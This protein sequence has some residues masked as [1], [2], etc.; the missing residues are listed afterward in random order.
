MPVAVMEQVAAAPQ[1]AKQLEA[2][3]ATITA[4]TTAASAS[5]KDKKMAKTDMDIASAAT[6]VAAQCVEA[7][8]AMGAECVHLIAA[9]NFAVNVKSHGNILTI[10][11]AAAT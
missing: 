1:L 10:T 11:A 6:L 7:A 5:R 8:E 4:A 2:A 9:V 3:V